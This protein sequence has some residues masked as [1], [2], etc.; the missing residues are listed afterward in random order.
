VWTKI[1]RHPKVRGTASPD[2]PS[3]KEYWAE[4]TKA[5][6]K[7]LKT[8]SLQKVAKDQGHIC[9]VCGETL[10]NGEELQLDHIVPRHKGGKDSYDNYQL[11][12]LDC[13]KQKT[14]VDLSKREPTRKWLRKWLA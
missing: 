4:R 1:E 3:L 14:A 10:Y 5:G 9:P 7:E 13:H 12:H 2:D 8:P 11:L 6:A